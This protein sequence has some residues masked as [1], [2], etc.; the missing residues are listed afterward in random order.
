[1]PSD[2]AELKADM[3][4]KKTYFICK[5]SAGSQGD[6]ITL[7]RKLADIRV[8]NKTIE[9]FIVQQYIHK[10]LLLYGKKFDL[11]IF[12]TIVQFSP[13]IAYVCDEGLARFCTAPYKKPT[14]ANFSNGYMH[15]TNYT[16]NKENPNFVHTD[17]LYKANEGSK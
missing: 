17:E 5:P 1:M 9:D 14:R 16:L 3:R 12:V 15:L 13:M 4:R 8:L 10:P 6:G 2:K 7:I 11:R